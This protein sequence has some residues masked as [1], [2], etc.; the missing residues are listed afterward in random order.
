[1]H[2]VFFA[3]EA[4][5]TRL[6]DV[7]AD[8]ATGLV[9][10]SSGEPVWNQLDE[11]MTWLP[12]FWTRGLREGYTKPQILRRRQAHVR[13]LAAPIWAQ[14]DQWP[15]LDPGVEHVYLL[16][17]FGFF[18][19]GHLF[20]S[21]QRLQRCI[22]VVPRPLRVV[23]AQASR[24]IDFDGHMA[25]FGVGSDELLALAGPA[26]IPRLWISPWQSHPAQLTAKAYDE[27]YARYTCGT[28]ASPRTRLYLSR[29]HVRPGFRGVSNE[30]E[31]LPIISEHGFEVLTGNEPLAHIVERFYKA[32]V[33]MGPHG[34]LFAN[35]MFCQEDC[36]VVEFCPDNRLDYSF[37]KKTKRCKDYRHV[38]LP[39]DSHFNI[40]IPP[41]ELLSVLEQT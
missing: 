22:D 14:R 21:L 23:H 38:A 17:P 35:V 39:G 41:Q 3:P 18:A 24:I 15:R 37:Q 29:N 1:M 8:P 27:I 6:S 2:Q 30:S 33:I 11:V 9:L 20:D 26:W 16:H 36:R 5:V 31:L 25:K 10:D 32:E 19:F 34:S 4:E 28:P 7:L 13:A 12:D 40:T